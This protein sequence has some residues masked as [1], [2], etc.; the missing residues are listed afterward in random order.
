M[1]HNLR[2]ISF[3]EERHKEHFAEPR[4]VNH[5]RFMAYKDPK[6]RQ[7]WLKLWFNEAEK[8]EEKNPLA[9]M[10]DEQEESTH[11]M[12]SMQ[13]ELYEHR[14]MSYYLPADRSSSSRAVSMSPTRSS[15]HLP[16]A[17]SSNPSSR[18]SSPDL[19]CET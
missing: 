5:F 14:C 4:H 2:H 8:A 19:G 6:R 1:K 17:T 7:M 12:I 18:S 11:K 9:H 3:S 16:P 15:Y 13:L 10:I